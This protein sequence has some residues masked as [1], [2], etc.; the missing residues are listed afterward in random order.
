MTNV[1]RCDVAGH[2]LQRTDPDPPAGET[3]TVVDVV[4]CP[5]DGSPARLLG[6]PPPA[7]ESVI[8]LTSAQ[9]VPPPP[10]RPWREPIRRREIRHSSAGWW[11]VTTSHA[12]PLRKALA[13]VLEATD[14]DEVVG[15]ATLAEACRRAGVLLAEIDRQELEAGRP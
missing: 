10:E 6:G 11:A 8:E 12:F 4:P 9:A 2:Y 3:V 5:F 7:G 13:D 14:D 1:W 15:T